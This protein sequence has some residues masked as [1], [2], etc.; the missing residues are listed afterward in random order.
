M[1]WIIK[2]HFKARET[3][4]KNDVSL[5]AYGGNKLK[6]E[7]LLSGFNWKHKDKEIFMD[8]KMH[9]TY[10]RATCLLEESSEIYSS[11]FSTINKASR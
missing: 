5:C 3:L 1:M 8:H 11:W 10:E 6:A 2:R 7:S 9:R 4:K